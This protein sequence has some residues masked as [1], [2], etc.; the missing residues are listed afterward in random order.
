MLSL[1]F[2]PHDVSNFAMYICF[3][4]LVGFCLLLGFLFFLIF[5]I[6]HLTAV[7]KYGPRA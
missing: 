6:A 7:L 3:L 5:N 1:P 4:C 2:F